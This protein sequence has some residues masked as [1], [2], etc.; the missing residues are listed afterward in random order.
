MPIEFDPTMLRSKADSLAASLAAAR[1][2][3][4]ELA[5]FK[6]L[7]VLTRERREDL[8]MVHLGMKPMATFFEPILDIRSRFGTDYVAHLAKP[9]IVVSSKGDAIWNPELVNEAL[10]E[11]FDLVEIVAN[12]YPALSIE[13]NLE[14]TQSPDFSR[15]VRMLSNAPGDD[16]EA[17]ILEGVMLGYPKEACEQFSETFPLLAR[18]VAVVG[19]VLEERGEDSI[20]RHDY[21]LHELVENKGGLKDELLKVADTLPRKINPRILD[22][23]RKLK[24]ANVPGSRFITFGNLTTDYERK[25]REAYA[26]SGIEGSISL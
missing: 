11:N 13:L 3:G 15:F 17:I 4:G 9:G 5:P 1:T 19:Q 22:L 21:A 6:N 16:A 8:L 10:A 18:L 2:S 24:F 23:V 12:R 7:D 14:S 20:L 26:G 25:I